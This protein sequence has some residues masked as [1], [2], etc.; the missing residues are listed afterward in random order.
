MSGTVKREIALV[1]GGVVAVLEAV[2]AGALSMSSTAHA[3][4]GLV[5][6]FLGAVGIRSQVTPSK[7]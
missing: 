6:V 3:V 5:L 1:I 2:Q 7:S 4:V